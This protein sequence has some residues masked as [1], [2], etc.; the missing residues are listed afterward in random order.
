MYGGI[1]IHSGML[2]VG[3][4]IIPNPEKGYP[5]VFNIGSNPVIIISKLYF[6]KSKFMG[7]IIVV[8]TLLFYYNFIKK[9]E[10]V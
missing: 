2:N 9:E 8:L 10:N 7:I 1:G 5:L 6:I 3:I 4:D